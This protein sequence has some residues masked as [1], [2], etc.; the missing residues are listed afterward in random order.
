[1]ALR[2][3]ALWL[4]AFPAFVLVTPVAQAEE[5][6]TRPPAAAYGPVDA[7]RSD[8][9]IDFRIDAQLN[10]TRGD[11]REGRENG[12]L[13]RQQARDYRKQAGRISNTATMARR[14][15]GGMTVSEA[16]DL[17]MQAR[18]LDSVVNAPASMGTKR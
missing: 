7:V 12:Q 5:L 16:R 1:M 3:S 4:A 6:T 9:V 18:M 8:E 11:I 13:S 15:P 14:R 10:E 17:G 2:K